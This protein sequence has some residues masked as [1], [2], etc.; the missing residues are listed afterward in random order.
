MR[1]IEAAL[2]IDERYR[3][4]ALADALVWC[5]ALPI[6]AGFAY[7]V[8]QMVWLNTS[9]RRQAVWSEG[10][11]ST[12]A[13]IVPT[14]FAAKHLR[15][16]PHHARAGVLCCAVTP[17]AAAALGGVPEVHTGLLERAL[18]VRALSRRQPRAPINATQPSRRRA[19]ISPFDDVLTGRC[20][21]TR[22]WRRSDRCA[23]AATRGGGRGSLR[24]ASRM[25]ACA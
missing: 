1:P 16:Q 9:Q 19:P 10:F 13:R 11:Q 6:G 3:T 5:G 18:A 8:Q 15:L 17:A 24:P 12:R 23:A 21:R 7:C 20:H 25:R 22:R 2:Q 14:V 4:T